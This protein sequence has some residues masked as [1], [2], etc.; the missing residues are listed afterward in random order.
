MPPDPAEID[1]DVGASVASVALAIARFQEGDESELARIVFAFHALLLGKADSKLR[2]SPGL[3]SITDADGAVASAIASYWKAV[4]N[5]RFRDMKHSN[6]LLGV[7][8]TMVERKAGRQVRK[9]MTGKAGR[10]RISNEPEAGLEA[11]AREASPVDVLIEQES[12]ARLEEVVVRWHD[13]MREKDLLNVAELML[14]GLG[15]REIAENLG[16]RESKARRLITT[17]NTLTREF[18]KKEIPEE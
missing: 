10:G 4:K 14:E 5:G 11:A 15:Y 18:G 7:L 12:I 9:N 13:H 1:V 17:V 3:R 6:E 16:I 8:V 2:K